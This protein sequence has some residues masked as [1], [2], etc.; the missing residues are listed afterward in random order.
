MVDDVYHLQINSIF[1]NSPFASLLGA[2]KANKWEYFYQS[3]CNLPFSAENRIPH[4]TKVE[5]AL[6]MHYTENKKPYYTYKPSFVLFGKPC[7]ILQ[8]RTFSLENG[9][10]REIAI[11]QFNTPSSEKQRMSKII[12]REIAF[13]PSGD[14]SPHRYGIY[15]DISSKDISLHSSKS[16]KN[17]AAK[18]CNNVF[19]PEAP[20]FITETLDDDAYALTRDVLKYLVMRQSS[21]D[22]FSEYSIKAAQVSLKSRFECIMSNY[23]TWSWKSNANGHGPQDIAK[24]NTFYHFGD[25]EERHLKTPKLW[26]S[27]INSMGNVSIKFAFCAYVLGF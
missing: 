5:I 3:V 8:T 10:L 13:G 7:M 23:S 25:C 14:N 15:F 16:K 18:N 1:Q 22:S 4:K 9:K 6:K 27:F 20:F 19:L 11:R 21:D 26:E 24:V 12:A 2:D 17:V